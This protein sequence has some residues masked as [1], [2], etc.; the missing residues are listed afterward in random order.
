M[1]AQQ[2]AFHYM[3]GNILQK[4]GRRAEAQQ[5]YQKGNQLEKR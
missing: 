3:R 1:D 5:A 4:L 2:P